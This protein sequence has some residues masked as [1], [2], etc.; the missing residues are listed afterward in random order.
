M[1]EITASRKIQSPPVYRIR[2]FFNRFA[3]FLGVALFLF[4]ILLPFY[5]IFISSF[6]PKYQM[7]QIPPRW[8]P[9]QVTFENYIHLAANIPFFRY[10]ANSLIFALFSGAVSVLLSFMAAYA[11]ARVRFPGSNLIFLVFVITI[12]IPQIGT[13]V[14]L[15]EMYKRLGL[16]NSRFGMILLMSSLVLPFTI[17]T[18]VSFI[19]QIPVEMEEAAR[20]DGANLTQ[21]L[22]W[23]VVPVVKPALATMLIIN[24]II[25]WN[26]LLYPLVFATS[27]MTKTLSVGLVEL[28]VD[29]SMGAGRPWDL[30]SALSVSM[31]I[32]VLLL[33]LIFQRLIVSGLTKGAI[34]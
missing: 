10:Y 15:F 26:E 17:W 21:I 6:T 33:V 2:R 34:K 24:F 19:Q 14:P 12:A 23:I 31:I 5:W 3:L 28:S 7:F 13:L 25:S 30:M 20:I 8:I 27:Q 4:V 18:M 1:A 29:P 32:P 11:L 16:V 22:W 9:A